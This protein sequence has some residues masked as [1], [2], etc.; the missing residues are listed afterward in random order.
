M[1]PLLAMLGLTR[2]CPQPSPL[3]LCGDRKQRERRRR[4]AEVS[5]IGSDTHRIEG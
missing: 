1:W 4:M 5:V 2:L 3:C